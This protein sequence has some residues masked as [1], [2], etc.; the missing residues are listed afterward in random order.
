MGFSCLGLEMTRKQLE[1]LCVKG[2]IRRR[3]ESSLVDL[4]I[5]FKAYESTLS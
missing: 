4:Y 2:R 3:Q 1:R 5:D